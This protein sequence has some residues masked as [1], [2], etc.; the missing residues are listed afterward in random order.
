MNDDTLAPTFNKGVWQPGPQGHFYY[1]FRDDHGPMVAM[2]QIKDY[3]KDQF[4]RQDESVFQM[5]HLRNIIEKTEDR[6]EKAHLATTPTQFYN[7]TVEALIAKVNGY[8][9]LPEYAPVL[10]KDQTDVYPAGSGKPRYRVNQMDVP[11]QWEVEQSTN[12]PL[13]T[14]DK[15]NVKEISY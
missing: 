2:S 13:G 10:V 12:A 6:A 4:Q 3:M 1:P 9:G 8:F 7:Q 5:N 15:V 11:T 14:G